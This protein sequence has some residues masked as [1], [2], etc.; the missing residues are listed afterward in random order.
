MNYYS[1]VDDRRWCLLWI[2]HDYITIISNY[3]NNYM[4]H[5]EP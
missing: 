1:D 4:N 5:Y 2:D 3:I